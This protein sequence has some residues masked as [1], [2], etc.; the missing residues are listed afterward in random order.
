MTLTL[1]LTNDI[2]S[3]WEYK[4]AKKKEEGDFNSILNSIRKWVKL[5]LIYLTPKIYE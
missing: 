1:S 2:S 3:I 5:E 4:L